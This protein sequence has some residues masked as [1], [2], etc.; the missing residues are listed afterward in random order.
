MAATDT[1]E[2]RPSKAVSALYIEEQLLVKRIQIAKRNLELLEREL[3]EV[4]VRQSY[5]R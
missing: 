2:S 3:F 1:A 4:Q 5:R